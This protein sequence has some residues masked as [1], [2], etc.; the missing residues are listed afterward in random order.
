MK[1]LLFIIPLILLSACDNSS[2][3]IEDSFFSSKI[4]GNNGLSTLNKPEGNYLFYKSQT[5]TFIKTNL[6][7]EEYAD[8]IYDYLKNDRKY[9]CVY[10]IKGYNSKYSHLKINKISYYLKD[11]SSLDDFYFKEEES[12]IFVYSNTWQEKNDDGDPYLYSAKGIKINNISGI[13]KY[14]NKE[15]IYNWSIQIMIGTAFYFMDN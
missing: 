5:K 11:C 12:W 13:E 2:K 3:Y 9:Q 14:D 6:S 7:A 15:F 4:L 1:R 8:R 10:G